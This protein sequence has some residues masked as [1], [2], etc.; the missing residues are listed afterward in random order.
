MDGEG[1]YGPGNI[2]LERLDFGALPGKLWPMFKRVWMLWPAALMTAALCGRAGESGLNVIVVVNQNSSNSLQLGNDYC[3]RRGVPPQNLFRMTGWTGGP[4]NWQQSDFTNFL[5][6]P[7][8]AMISSRAL[9]HQA[10]IILLSMDI[11]Y[12]VFGDGNLS[13]SENSTTSALF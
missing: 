7:L 9:T 11:P 8:L 3:E 6:N 4:V 12:R 10:D 2:S 13:D 5:L 1:G